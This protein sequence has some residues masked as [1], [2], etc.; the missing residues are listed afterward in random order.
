MKWLSKFLS[1]EAVADAELPEAA[2]TDAE[3]SQDITSRS[4]GADVTASDL[5]ARY[6]Q[7]VSALHTKNDRLFTNNVKLAAENAAYKRALEEIVAM[8][9]IGCAHI[10]KRM[11]RAANNALVSRA[12]AKLEG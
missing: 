4:I 10:G 6:E 5:A 9:T 1:P 12:V 2:Y 8:E 7:L 3:K 11:A